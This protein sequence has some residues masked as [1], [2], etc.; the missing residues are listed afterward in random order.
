MRLAWPPAASPLLRN[1]AW[2]HDQRD[3]AL[4]EAS[5]GADA[6]SAVRTHGKAATFPS[7]RGLRVSGARGRVLY[8]WGGCNRHRPV[9]DETSSTAGAPSQSA[10]GAALPHQRKHRESYDRAQ[11]EC[12]PSRFIRLLPV[13]PAVEILKVV[14][15][16][17]DA[18][19]GGLG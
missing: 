19:P 13:L 7:G 5:D 3:R 16:L 8:P 10:V 6:M 14:G 11:P 2:S 17:L 9:G 15:P 1:V 18:E 4:A 12:E